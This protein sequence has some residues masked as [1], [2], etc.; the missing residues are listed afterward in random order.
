MLPSDLEI[1]RPEYLDQP[2]VKALFIRFLDRLRI[3]SASE[4]TNRM[5]ESIGERY[6]K[7]LYNPTKTGDGELLW[8]LL[9]KC[10]QDNFIK[11]EATSRK[12]DPYKPEWYNKYRIVFNVDYEG[13]FRVWLNRPL[14][15]K[16]EREWQD[17]VNQHEQCFSRSDLL[18]HSRSCFEILKKPAEEVIS[19]LT[20]IPDEL[21]KKPMTAYQLS[22]KI[23]W[24]CSKI[25]ESKKFGSDG[26]EKWI[27]DLFD[28]PEGMV[29]ER[30]ILIEVHF[31]STVPEGIM[32][33][34]NMDSYFSACNGKWPGCENFILVYA[35]GYKLSSQRIRRADYSRFHLS[36]TGRIQ[37]QQFDQFR[38]AWFDKSP[39]S[40]PV[41]FIGDLDWEGLKIFY[42]LKS[43]FPDLKP[44][45]KG[46]EKLIEAREN[47]QCHSPGM[48]NKKG[49]KQIDSTSDDWLDEHILKPMK[50]RSLF[51]DQEVIG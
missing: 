51:V 10:E 34:E 35:Q 1:P 41:Y 20:S 50:K 24:G 2:A 42:S 22:A 4:R 6:F 13:A 15:S 48:A 8:G 26:C 12:R 40:Y 43:I 23:F 29:L 28:L 19:R 17:A 36:A 16:E 47:G 11:L 3:Q 5:T 9:E 39:F 46:Y 45:K 30:P 44:W 7:D 49:Q 27:K 21:S 32:I 33:V 38:S 18:I 37:P 14:I 25:F 31:P